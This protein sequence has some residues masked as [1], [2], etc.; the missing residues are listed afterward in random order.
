MKHALNESTR[1]PVEPKTSELDDRIRLRAY[2]LYEQRGRRDGSELEDW[3]R[4]EN[5][6]LG[7]NDIARAS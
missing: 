6:V 3:V 4:A 5:E 2:E 1:K 7:S